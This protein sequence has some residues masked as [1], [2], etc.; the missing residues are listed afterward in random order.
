MP[1]TINTIKDLKHK[2]K[3]IALTAYDYS[4]AKALDNAGVDIILVGDSLAQVALGYQ[5]TLSITMEE[6]LHHTKAVVRGVKNSL[7][8]ADMPFMSYQVSIKEA[9]RNAGNFLQVGAHSVKL[10]GATRSIL[11]TIEKMNNSGIPVLGHVGFTPQSINALGG[12]R[13]QGK[14]AEAAKKL[15]NQAKDLQDA[16]CFA[17]VI[18]LVPSEVAALISESIEIPTIGIG[19]GSDCDGQILVTDDLIGKFTDFKPS[20]VRRYAEV[21][22]ES[23]AAV[24]NFIFDVQN[25]KYPQIHES[26]Y[27]TEAEAQKIIGVKS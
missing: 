9:V 6:M 21:G 27:M 18:E 26:F 20:F 15:L 23:E 25:R 10:E 14:T 4:I 22:R 5:N 12:N 24:R 1:V 11:R 2:R 8:V 3:I 13:V 17:L 7:V 16:G 19:A